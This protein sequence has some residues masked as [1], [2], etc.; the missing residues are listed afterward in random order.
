MQQEKQPFSSLRRTSGE[1]KRYRTYRRVIPV[2][3]GAIVALLVVMY[4]CSLLFARYGSFTVAVKDYSDRN[5]ALSLSESDSFLHPTSR[6][7]GNAVKDITNIDG[8]TLPGNLNDINGEHNGDNYIAYTFYLKNSGQLA[9]SYNYQL[10]ISMATVGVD[11]AARVRL[12]FTPDYYKAATGEYNYGG[13][14]TD[15]AKPRTNGNGAPEVDPDNRVMTNFSSSNTVCEAQVDDFQSGDMAKITV[16][17]WL[18][19][20]DPDCTDEVLGGPFKLDYIV[21]IVEGE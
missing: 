10:V 6:L 7:N 11:A 1:V 21:S 13:N 15:Y 18:E 5:Y 20:N 14:Y 4:V 8:N 3:I 12:Y 2:G 17:I 19:G 16:V 9:C